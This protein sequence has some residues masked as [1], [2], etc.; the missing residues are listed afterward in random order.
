MQCTWSELNLNA[1]IQLILISGLQLELLRAHYGI[2]V[3]GELLVLIN[4]E[5]DNAL[6]QTVMI[7]SMV[8]IS[9]NSL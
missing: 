6:C 5:I 7:I 4:Y 9:Q 3:H 1:L 2:V 8:G